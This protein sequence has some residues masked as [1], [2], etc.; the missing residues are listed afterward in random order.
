MCGC[1]S[2]SSQPGAAKARSNALVLRVE[3]MACGHCAGTIKKAIEAGLP[4]TQVEADPSSKLV[5]VRGSVD[6]ASIKALVTRA[7]YTPTA[8]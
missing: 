3:D 8:A 1:S 4:G 7:G 2:H 5:S 6:L